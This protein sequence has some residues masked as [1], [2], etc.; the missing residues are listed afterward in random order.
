[1]TPVIGLTVSPFYFAYI[2]MEKI[3]LTKL[4]KGYYTA[5]PHPEL[6]TVEAADFLSI[7]GKG[8]PSSAEYAETIQA[9]YA[10]AYAV[11][12]MYKADK[13]D[14]TVAKL[15]G[16]WW[17]D[18]AKYGHVS[19]EDAPLKIPRSEW[20]YRMLIRMPDFVTAE[21][22]SNAKEQVANKKGIAL[23]NTV[24]LYPMNEGLCIQ[25]LHVGPFNT[26]HESLQLIKEFSETN[27]LQKNGLHHEIYL[28]DFRKTAPEKLKTIL[29]EPVKLN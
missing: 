14:F 20:E 1:M 7:R 21:A 24:E 5:K 23:A 28:S 27:R 22:I 25:M 6:V 12:F 13:K 18:A 19:M 8:D 9:L 26:E 15:E 16:L 3:D 29:R 2:I 17:F 4:H 11:K 10:T